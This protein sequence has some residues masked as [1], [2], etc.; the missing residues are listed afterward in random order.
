[1]NL[2]DL[3]QQY[4]LKEVE[5]EKKILVKRKMSC[6]ASGSNC[7]CKSIL[8][9]VLLAVAQVEELS[10]SGLFLRQVLWHNFEYYCCL[11]TLRY[12][13]PVQV[14]YALLISFKHISLL[15]QS[16]IIGFSCLHLRTQIDTVGLI[17]LMR[18]K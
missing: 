9:P 18:K 12:G 6:G 10:Y 8:G 15:L 7:A 3:T 5:P 14:I 4:T 1:M 16:A 17:L 11:N 13:R 2:P